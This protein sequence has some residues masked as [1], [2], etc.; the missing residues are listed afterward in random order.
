M[1]L[2]NTNAK[3]LVAGLLATDGLNRDFRSFER[4]ADLHDA[5]RP[6]RFHLAADPGRAFE[7]QIRL[8]SK[9]YAAFEANFLLRRA[10]AQVIHFETAVAH[11]KKA[12]AFGP[13]A[14][15]RVRRARSEARLQIP[16]AKFHL[17]KLNSAF[18]LQLVQQRF[19]ADAF[20]FQLERAA[21]GSGHAFG[22]FP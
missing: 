6:R 21:E 16:S 17:L 3:Y 13:A 1:L 8:A 12:V 2:G 14:C 22:N 4:A 18:A 15:A 9:A 10:K 20:R 7:R 11:V 5:F 19:A